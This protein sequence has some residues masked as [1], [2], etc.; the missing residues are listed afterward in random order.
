MLQKRSNRLRIS[1]CPTTNQIVD[2]PATCPT[3]PVRYGVTP[4]TTC[5]RVGEDV[6]DDVT[7]GFV[8]GLAAMIPGVNNFW[9]PLAGVKN[10][11]AT[12]QQAYNQLSN[13]WNNCI[14]QYCSCI[15]Q[16][17]MNYLQDQLASVQTSQNV[18]NEQL[19]EQ[20]STDTTFIIFLLAMVG[21]LF[22][23]IVLQN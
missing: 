23:Y 22:T 18:V 2:C 13:A 1:A 20:I 11:V 4:W 5:P 15:Q 10:S 7:A 16:D 21:L 12:S 8:Y 9:D 19:Q 3:P 6:A 14:S 17:Q